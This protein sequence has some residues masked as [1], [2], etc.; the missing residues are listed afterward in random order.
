[1]GPRGASKHEL[2]RIGLC[3][4]HLSCERL[5]AWITGTTQ[6]KCSNPAA[7]R[8]ALCFGAEVR[9]LTTCRSFEPVGPTGPG[10]KPGLFLF[11]RG[12]H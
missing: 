12:P 9:R 3:R 2:G 1:M 4:V 5:T 8:A 7:E 6:E 11:R 10:A